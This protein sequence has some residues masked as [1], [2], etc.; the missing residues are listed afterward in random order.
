MTD[1]KRS[2][3]DRVN[4]EWCV[5]VGVPTIGCQGRSGHSAY[6]YL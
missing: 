6:D 5:V 4:I 2:D 1:A 3:I